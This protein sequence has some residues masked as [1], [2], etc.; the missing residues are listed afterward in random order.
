[1]DV[2]VNPVY[3][4][5]GRGGGVVYAAAD[6]EGSEGNGVKNWQGEPEPCTHTR[7]WRGVGAS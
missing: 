7:Y 3:Y 1:M 6:T 5:P 4:N 2:P